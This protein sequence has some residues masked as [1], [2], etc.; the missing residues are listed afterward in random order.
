VYSSGTTKNAFKL[1]DSPGSLES[2][3]SLQRMEE[4]LKAGFERG[5]AV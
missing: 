2:R 1:D 3:G 5:V 4:E